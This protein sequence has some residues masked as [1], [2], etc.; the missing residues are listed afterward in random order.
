MNGGTWAVIATGES[1]RPDPAAVAARVRHLP[2][3]AVNDAYLIAPWARALVSSDANWFGKH[4]AGVAA[5]AGEVWSQNAVRGVQRM[6]GWEGIFTNTNSGLLG[7]HFAVNFRGA[8]RVLLLGIDMKGEHY[9]GAHPV[10]LTANTDPE[11]FARF[12]RQFED[13]QRRMRPGVQVVNCSVSS[14]LECFPKLSLDDALA[15]LEPELV[16]A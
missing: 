1:M 16:A 2:C 7:L 14:A 11:K 6:P 4:A 9:F 5:F 3:I 8:D 13:F 15:A 12:I 10:G